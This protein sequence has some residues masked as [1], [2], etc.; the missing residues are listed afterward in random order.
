MHSSK[1]VNLKT[2]LIWTVYSVTSL[3]ISLVAFVEGLEGMLNGMVSNAL[4]SVA[5]LVKGSFQDSFNASRY[6]N[7]KGIKGW[8]WVSII[9]ILASFGT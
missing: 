5:S 1:K 8:H 3:E 7:G 9:P 6:L 2:V 4:L